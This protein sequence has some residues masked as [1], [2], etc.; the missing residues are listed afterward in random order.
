LSSTE[1]VDPAILSAHISDVTHSQKQSCF[2][3]SRDL[4]QLLVTYLRPAKAS[5]IY[6]RDAVP[7]VC[8]DGSDL[9]CGLSQNC[10]LGDLSDLLYGRCVAESNYLDRY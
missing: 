5:E 7:V 8:Y 1:N 2:H 9:T 10:L 4:L 6:I 3:H